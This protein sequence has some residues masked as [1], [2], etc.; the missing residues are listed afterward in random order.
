MIR[1]RGRWRHLS[2]PRI[3][4]ILATSLLAAAGQSDSGRAQPL[5]AVYDAIW[6]GVPAARI[7]LE[8]GGDGT[9][10][11]D[12][13]VIRTDGLLH[14]VTRFR[15]SA[16]AAGSVGPTLSVEPLHYDAVYD[17][18]KRRNSRV[19]M[20]FVVR[21]GGVIAERG[22]GDTSRKPPLEEGYRHDAVDPLSALERIRETLRAS[23]QRGGNSFSIPVYDGARRFDLRGRVLPISGGDGHSLQVVLTFLPIAGFKGESSDDGDP[24]DAP[25]PAR[26]VVSD[27]AR[28]LPISF[29]V[30]V[31]NFPLVVRLDHL[32]EVNLACAL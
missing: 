32:C 20:R 8:L 10:Y 30:Q 7:R 22:P 23:L 24:D 13:I 21:G 26:L 28:L 18:R 27:D 6:A 4:G 1:D 31:F 12:A 29:E 3:A 25:R 9:R 16:T 14:L 2:P 17:L 15:A 11:Q 19:S 5:V